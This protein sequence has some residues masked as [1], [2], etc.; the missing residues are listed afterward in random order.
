LAAGAAALPLAILR[1]RK[2]LAEMVEAAVLLLEL[3]RRGRVYRG[4]DFLLELHRLPIGRLEVVVLV[5]SVE[6]VRQVS[7]EPLGLVQHHLLQE[8]Q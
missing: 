3:K 4:K 8:H 5:V 7:M 6:M 1:L 2:E